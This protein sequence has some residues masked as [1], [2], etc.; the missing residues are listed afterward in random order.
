[1]SI[2]DFNNTVALICPYLQ[3]VCVFIQPQFESLFIIIFY[4]FFYIGYTKFTF[5]W[6]VV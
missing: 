5:D 3:G 2:T 1:M 6:F 4:Y